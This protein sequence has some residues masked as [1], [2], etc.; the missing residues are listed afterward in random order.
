MAENEVFTGKD[1]E[2]AIAAG[3]AALGLEREQVKVEILD[4]GSKGV[5][6]IGSRPASVRLTAAGREPVP[7][8]FEAAAVPAVP[9]PPL[10][11][12]PE[13]PPA[14]PERDEEVERVAT[15]VL[16]EL[17]DH[18]G[19]EAEIR[20]SYAE[21]QPDEQDAPLV[22][23][24]YGPQV[25]SLIGRRGETLAAL[26]RILRLIVGNRLAQRANIVLDI[27]GYKVEREQKLRGLAERMADRAVGSG[28]TVSLEPMSPYERRIIHVALRDRTDVRTES[29]GEGRR[30]R[31]TIIPSVGK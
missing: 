28:Q 31:V 25:D 18:L 9:A 19:F 15:T 2:D 7:E 12:I 11:A 16:I 13:A 30:R 26:Q 22:L 29:V 17:M 23:D 4:A 21:P 24:V 1:I 8:T 20:T 6:G 14:A 10:A 5:F 27:R 3:L